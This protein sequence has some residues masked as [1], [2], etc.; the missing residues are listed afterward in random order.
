M[1]NGLRRSGQPEGEKHER[2][3]RARRGR[4]RPEPVVPGS[5]PGSVILVVL[6]NV[7]VKDGTKYA[8]VQTGSLN[9]TGAETYNAIHKEDGRELFRYAK[10]VMN[11]G[12]SFVSFEPGEWTDWSEA[13]AVFGARGTNVNMAYD[14][15]PVKAYVYP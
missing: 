14:N 12:E 4:V 15:L 8:L 13:A 7:P 1:K 2:A 3:F 5:P 10:G 11:P 6:E 9:R